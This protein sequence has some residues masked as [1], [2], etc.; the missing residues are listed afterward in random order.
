MWV[1]IYIYVCVGELHVQHKGHYGLAARQGLDAHLCKHAHTSLCYTHTHAH[2]QTHTHAFNNHI[3]G[4]EGMSLV[5]ICAS[6]HTLFYAAH[7]RTHIHKHTHA[8]NNCIGGFKG[9]SLVFICASMHTLLYAAH[10]RTHIHKHTH[11]RLTIA[12]KVWWVCPWYSMVQASTH[13]SILHA[14]THRYTYVYKLHRRSWG[15]VPDIHLD[16]RCNL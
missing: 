9:M 10:T 11:M 2:T 8:F 16:L 7:T 14:H 3:G 5:F 6:M 12:L 13:F 1:Y 15:Y 4:F